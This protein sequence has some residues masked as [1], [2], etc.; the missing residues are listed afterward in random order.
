MQK[1][2]CLDR[3]GLA[4]ARPALPASCP[5]RRESP[6]ADR[7]KDRQTSEREEEG[8]LRVCVWETFYM[9]W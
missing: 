4:G 3:T 9:Q 8:A 6:I 7:E 5:I 2:T 1:D